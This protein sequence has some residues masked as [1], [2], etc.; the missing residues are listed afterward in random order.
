ML[1]TIMKLIGLE[2]LQLGSESSI[3]LKW[4]IEAVHYKSCRLTSNYSCSCP[5]TLVAHLV[6]IPLEADS[7]SF[8]M[9]SIIW[10]S[11]I[12]SEVITYLLLII[13]R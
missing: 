13:E 6:N 8:V 9:A 1:A 12:I 3:S 10:M 7:S 4:Y 2:N 5:E 11:K